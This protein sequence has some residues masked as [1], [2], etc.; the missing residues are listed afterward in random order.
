MEVSV[1]PKTSASTDSPWLGLAKYAWSGW[2]LQ[3][4]SLLSVA[5]TLH[6][7]LDFQYRTEVNCLPL[8]QIC[9]WV[10]QLWGGVPQPTVLVWQPR[11]CEHC[12]EDRNWACLARG[13]SGCWIVF[14]Y[15]CSHAHVY[16]V[17]DT[18]LKLIPLFQSRTGEFFLLLALQ[19][20]RSSG[21]QSH[22]HLKKMRFPWFLFSNEYPFHS[23]LMDFWKTT[24]M[25]PSVCWMGWISWH[26]QYLNLAWDPQKLWPPGWQ[27]RLPQLTG[28]PT[29]RSW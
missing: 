29:L 28:D 3:L 21:L 5:S 14:V 10:P 18:P 9:D 26:N 16:V 11:S 22:L 27:T 7:A 19:F 6:G 15:M 4:R 12:S 25:Q 20:N 1:V 17:N 8:L 24:T 2:V 13:K 23:R